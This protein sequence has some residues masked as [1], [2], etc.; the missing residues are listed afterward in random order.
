MDRKFFNEIGFYL[1]KKTKGGFMA[2]LFYFVVVS[3]IP[4]VFGYLYFGDPLFLIELMKVQFPY[5][6]IPCF[7]FI[8]FVLAIPL[9]RYLK[10]INDLQSKYVCKKSDYWDK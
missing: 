8:A 9:S 4:E 7:L 2:I 1:F 6:F 3:F 10:T 5:L